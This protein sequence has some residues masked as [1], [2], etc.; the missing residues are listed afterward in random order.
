MLAVLAISAGLLAGCGGG[1]A[2]D[3]GHA[4]IEG[5]GNWARDHAHEF[6]DASAEAI[7]SAREQYGDDGKDLVCFIVQN[8]QY[9]ENTG[10]YALPSEADVETEVAHKTFGYSLTKEAIDDIYTTI[11]D[12]STGQVVKAYADAGCTAKFFS[13]SS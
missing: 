8:S 10:S 1:T 5:F 7:D 2:V 13:D 4:V 6:A 3:A 11:E 9:N 12:E